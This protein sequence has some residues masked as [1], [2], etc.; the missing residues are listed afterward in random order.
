MDIACCEVTPA[1][2][3]LL[4]PEQYLA[5]VRTGVLMAKVGEMYQTLGLQML[6]TAVVAGYLV[7]DPGLGVQDQVL[8]P[9]WQGL[10]AGSVSPF[11]P[12]TIVDPIED[13]KDQHYQ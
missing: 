12:G 11:A 10:P 7:I 3:A 8:L 13:E 6:V 4:G 2:A 5:A 9:G 1:P